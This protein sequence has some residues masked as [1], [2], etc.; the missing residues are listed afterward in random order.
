MSRPAR[1]RGLRVRGLVGG[2]LLVSLLGGCAARRKA[3]DDSLSDGAPVEVLPAWDA[4]D[5]FAADPDPSVRAR[6]LGSA[7]AYAPAAQVPRWIMQGSYDPDA[8]VQGAVVEA[9][10]LRD[11]EPE[12]HELLLGFVARGSADPYLRAVVAVRLGS[13]TPMS[14]RGAWG[15]QPL[16]RATPL[17]LAS[18]VAGDQPALDVLLAG[19]REGELRAEP[20]FLASLVLAEPPGAVEALAAGAARGEEMA[21]PLLLAGMLLGDADARVAWQHA[22]ADDP[23]WVGQ[24]ALEVALHLPAE[25]RVTV[26]DA[27]AKA[28]DRGVRE[29][30]DLLRRPNAKGMVRAAGDDDPWVRGMVGA[31]AREIPAEEAAPVA[32]ILIGDA[33]ALVRAEGARLVGH[34]RIRSLGDGVEALAADEAALVRAAAAGALAALGR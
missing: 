28:G 19:L 1:G 3:L 18:W 8:W 16:W 34:H 4:L 13:A 7:V 11:G 30:A 27:V 5:R 23:A 10:M 22:L 26:A 33:T 25:R 17:A 21:P 20:A 24:Q 14:V 32:A 29:V 2:V 12:V 6:A 9:M 15:R 31:L